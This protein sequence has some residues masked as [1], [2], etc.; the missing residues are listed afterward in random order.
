MTEETIEKYVCSGTQRDYDYV[1]LAPGSMVKIDRVESFLVG[2]DGGYARKDGDY[3]LWG[4]ALRVEGEKT[5]QGG[6]GEEKE[7][8]KGKMTRDG[9]SRS[10]TRQSSKVGNQKY[11]C[12]MRSGTQECSARASKPKK[13]GSYI[14]N[15]LSPIW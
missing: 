5:R 9:V 14:I 2:R 15:H 12:M 6:E 3:S 11:G 1:S 10:S 13:V 8:E 4:R 7:K